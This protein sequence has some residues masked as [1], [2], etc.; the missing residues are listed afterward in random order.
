MST[1]TRP[2]L[3]STPT[4]PAATPNRWAVLVLVGLAQ[5]MVVLDATIVNVAL[6]HN[7]ARL[8]VRCFI[9]ISARTSC[10]DFPLRPQECAQTLLDSW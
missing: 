9:A 3:P 7:M 10:T 8:K 6:A 1:L 2:R 5:L 4:Q